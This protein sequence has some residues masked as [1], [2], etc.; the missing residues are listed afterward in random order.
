M[1]IWIYTLILFVGMVQT[2]C[3]NRHPK[4]GFLIHAYDSPRWQNDEKYFTD[5]VKRLKG[6]V[7]VREAGND[8]NL[9]LKQAEELIRDGVSVLVVIPVDQYAAGRIVNLAHEN[10]L[11][12]IAYDRMINNCPLDYY[13]SAD[14]IKIGELQA[15][16]ISRTVREGKY[17]LIGGPLSDNNS[18]MIYVGQMNILDPLV[19]NGKITIPFK[20]FAKTWSTD[21]G[22]R[23]AITALDSTKNN[24]NAILCGN[25]AMAIGV[26][27]ALKERALD[28]KVAVAGQ[29]A[30]LRNIQEIVAG[31]QSMTVFKKIK[32]M[33]TTAAELAVGL[34]K[35]K[36]IAFSDVTIDNGNR[37]VP[38]YLVDAVGVNQ[39][40][41]KMTVVA[42]GYQQENEIFK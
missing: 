9:Q 6:K 12:V 18:W 36:P 2:S 29:D 24:L 11:K 20:G 41:I 3:L 33:A 14:N 28:G 25:D 38:S 22:Y 26:I 1:K 27:K 23:L 10:E 39:S 35:N 13:V 17:A 4:I 19:A 30:D 5:E 21:E 42:E 15:K 8:K 37:L 16:Y 32:T 7:L 34:S 31:N 40:N